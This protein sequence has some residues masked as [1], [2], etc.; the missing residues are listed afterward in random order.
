MVSHLM[1]QECSAPETLGTEEGTRVTISLRKGPLTISVTLVTA[2]N[3]SG[4]WRTG[5]A[6]LSCRVVSLELCDETVPIRNL[7]T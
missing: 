3:D 5:T 7:H 1:L 4:S 6:L 2:L